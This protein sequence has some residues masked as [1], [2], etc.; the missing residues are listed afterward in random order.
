MRVLP[1]FAAGAALLA[2]PA[3]AA[4]PASKAPAKPAA[5]AGQAPAEVQHAMLYLKVMI[6]GLQ[7]DKVEQPVKGALVGCLYGASL[8]KITES[9]DKLI[10]DNPGKVSR[11]N[12]SQV[13]SAILA[14][15][16]Y[17]PEGAAAAK[18]NPQPTPK[19]TGR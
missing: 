19:P 9:V 14:V 6:S 1:I 4:Q 2:V 12:P 3:L 15:C 5:A 8:G 17:K 10:A 13:L 18:P 11:D 16:G 7:S